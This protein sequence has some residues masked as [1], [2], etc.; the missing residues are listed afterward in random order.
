MAGVCSGPGPCDTSSNDHG[1]KNW[2]SKAGGFPDWFHA[3]VNAMRRKGKTEGRAVAIAWGTVRRWARGGG[4]VTPETRAKA[5]AMVA[6]LDAMRGAAQ[7]TAESTPAVEL[8]V[9]IATSSDGPSMTV[10]AHMAALRKLAAAHKR[11]GPS[12]RPKIRKA[13]GTHAKAIQAGRCADMAAEPS[14]SIDLSTKPNPGAAAETELI[15]RNRETPAGRA[16]HKFQPAKWTHPNG[17]PR[18]KL[19]GTEERIDGMCDGSAKDGLKTSAPGSKGVATANLSNAIDLAW[20][21]AKHPRVG[22]KF[23]PKGTQTQGAK[24]AGRPTTADGPSRHRQH[25]RPYPG[26]AQGCRRSQGWR[27]R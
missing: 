21:E 13:M 24:P 2:V 26:R 10:S 9:P 17:H 3:I 19:C 25:R 27:R 20:D 16:P 7:L 8:A 15:R 12:Q 18:C 23:A 11:A 5:A 22:G 1:G 14:P 4:N 6:Q